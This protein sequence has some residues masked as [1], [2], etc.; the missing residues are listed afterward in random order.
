MPAR[1]SRELEGPRGKIVTLLRRSSLTPNE[2]AE[3]LGV[4]HNA[5]R[6]Q[7]AALVQLGIIRKAGTQQR[8][9]RPATL[10][11]L[12][13]RGEYLLSNAYLPLLAQLLQTLGEQLPGENL[14]NLMRTVGRN[15]AAERP[16]T[17]G[18]LQRRVSAAVALLE[19]LGALTEAEPEDH[20]FII[21]GYG[22]M[23]SEAVN[24][25]PEVCRVMESLLQEFIGAPVEECCERTERPRCCFIIKPISDTG[26][27]KAGSNRVA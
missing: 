6:T 24:G 23:L 4:T 12:A 14:D 11:E 8:A 9:T 22:C 18:P 3:R 1:F 13:P 17:D 20:G 7:L 10:Y 26:I 27:E 5:V 2:I 16:R 21:R 25:R 15:L 19:D